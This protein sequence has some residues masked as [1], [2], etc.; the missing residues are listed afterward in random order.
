MARVIPKVRSDDRNLEW[1]SCP[2]SM[3]GRLDFWEISTLHYSTQKSIREKLNKPLLTFDITGQVEQGILYRR[4][5]ALMRN[6]SEGGRTLLHIFPTFIVS[7]LANDNALFLMLLEKTIYK[8][9]IHRSNGFFSQGTI[10]ICCARLMVIRTILSFP[11][12][13]G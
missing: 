2:L 6:F 3:V 9:S 13:V 7:P 8:K 10:P 11:S 4:T 12:H 1:G 5:T